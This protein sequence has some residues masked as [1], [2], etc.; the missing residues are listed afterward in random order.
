MFAGPLDLGID[1]DVWP[2]VW[3]GTAL[4][5]ALVELVFVGGTFLL[6]P[7]AASAFV[8]AILAFY[9]VPIEIQW[10][11]FIG[12]GT[13]LF[14]AL[15]RWARKF[16]NDA[17]NTPGVGAERLVG[18]T[19]IVVAAI[20]GDDVDRRGRVRIGSEEWGAISDV[21]AVIGEG[22]KVRVLD[23][24]GTRVVVEPLPTA[25]AGSAN[26]SEGS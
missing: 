11:V 13:V 22:A 25:T 16:V 5:F 10:A 19:G 20:P 24:R 12:G 6:L 14:F 8:A 17:P 3:L 26:E 23:M 1:I 7:W 21:D 15:Y 2:W 9:D 4:L 18:L